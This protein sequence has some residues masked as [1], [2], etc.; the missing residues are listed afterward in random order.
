MK[1]F[2][3]GLMRT[4]TLSLTRALQRLGLRSSHFEPFSMQAYAHLDAVC[5]TPVPM[6]YPYLDH[7]F[8]GSRFILTVRSP[9][10]WLR[11]VERHIRVDGWPERL[12]AKPPQGLRPDVI[13]QHQQI[14]G[15][16]L[17][18]RERYLRG[19]FRYC[20]GVV[21]YFFDR[22]GDLLLMDIPAGDGWERLC[23]FLGRPIPELPF[24]NEHRLADD[25]S[26]TQG[27][28]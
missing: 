3:I 9:G 22:P 13:R 5:D 6:L 18:H 15:T 7:L 26:G 21:D 20:A 23:P 27:P 25:G 10:T 12:G 8:P 16:V 14:F 24:P 2:G 28:A 1:V 4:G 19:Y 11:S 17:F